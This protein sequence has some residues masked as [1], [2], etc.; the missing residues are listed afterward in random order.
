MLGR[1]ALVALGMALGTNAF[2]QTAGQ[3]P[4]KAKAPMT[5]EPVRYEPVSFASLAGWAADDHA[6]AFATFVTSCRKL[7]P[8]AREGSTKVDL[9][10]PHVAPLID[11]CAAA[12]AHGPAIKTATDARRFFEQRFQPH[13]VVHS[14]PPGLLTA[15]YEP[16]IVGSRVAAGRFT[17]PI[18][19]RPPD[20]VNLVE[21]T[22][23]GAVG[24]ALTHA[25]KTA[26]GTAPYATRAEID[27]G[28]LKGRG[29]ELMYLADPVEV[30]FLQVQ[31]SGRVRLPDGTLVRVTYDGKNG[32]PYTSIGRHLIDT[33]V[34]GADRMSLQALAD[35]LRADPKRG[36]EVMWQNK[37]YVFFRELQGAEANA[38][39]GVLDIPL[40]PG[41][42]L[43]VDAGV[44]AL[45]LPVFVTSP[46]LTHAGDSSGFKR[47]MIAQD[48]GS[49]IRG[50]ERG[51]LFIGSGDAAAKIAGIT[52]HPGTFHVL[53]PVASA[54]VGLKPGVAEP[55][56]RPTGSLPAANKPSGAP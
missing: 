18:Y 31:G 8:A 19:R 34:I 30:F 42:S 23:R 15:Y 26:T 21:E 12:L 2:G 52:K 4:L 22:Q 17:T 5:R 32:H 33:G 11:A 38:P 24:A 53:L 20:L 6:A 40:T 39:H 56:A 25:R 51:D 28:A 41:R 44:H 29:L 9:N 47:L 36:R 43:A 46:T 16:V 37:S 3:L 50:P 48:V 49:A 10:A 45:G 7:V 54:T 14:G 35:W 55:A 1:C 27:G 13:R